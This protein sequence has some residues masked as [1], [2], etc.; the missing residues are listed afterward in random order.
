MIVWAILGESGEK[1]DEPV[2]YGVGVGSV[3]AMLVGFEKVQEVDEFAACVLR[4]PFADGPVRANS[5]TKQVGQRDIM[6]GG[7][8]EDQS[9]FYNG[10][11]DDSLPEEEEG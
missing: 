6:E 10:G 3:D 4:V 5:V 8:G 2:R 9:G 7:Y 11:R 1:C